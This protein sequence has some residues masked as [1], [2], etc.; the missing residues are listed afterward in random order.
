MMNF[1][2]V[3]EQFNNNEISKEK[4]VAQVQQTFSYLDTECKKAYSKRDEVKRELKELKENNTVDIRAY[5]QK[6]L[7]ETIMTAETDRDELV[8]RV[9][10][11][12]VAK[13]LEVVL[14][15]SPEQGRL[16]ADAIAQVMK[17][18]S[19]C[20]PPKPRIFHP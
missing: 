17:K 7:E 2:E 10:K 4:F 11:S 14:D 6:E 19:D 12:Y 13:C 3:I 5:F 8:Q 20:S 1:D 18:I 9:F 15:R 16:P